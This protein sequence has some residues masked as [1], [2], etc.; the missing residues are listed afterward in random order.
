MAACPK[1]C[2]PPVWVLKALRYPAQQVLLL[3]GCM[4]TEHAHLCCEGIRGMQSHLADSFAWSR[5]PFWHACCPQLL[6]SK[7]QLMQDLICKVADDEKAFR[8]AEFRQSCTGCEGARA[9]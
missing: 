6:A 4:F 2:W 7:Q 9:G 5:I 8:H 3:L 1:P